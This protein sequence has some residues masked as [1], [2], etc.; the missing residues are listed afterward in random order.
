MTTLRITLQCARL[1]VL[2]WRYRATR[3]AGQAVLRAV[4]RMTPAG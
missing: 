1:R 4:E 3:A 2:V